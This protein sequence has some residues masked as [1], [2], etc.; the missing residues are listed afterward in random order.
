[1]ICM[2]SYTIF[3]F[4]EQDPFALIANSLFS[5][6]LFLDVSETVAVYLF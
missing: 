2:S 5:G 1:M 6:F 3:L 4:Y